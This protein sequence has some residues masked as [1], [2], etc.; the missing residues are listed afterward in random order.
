MRA[1]SYSQLSALVRYL[2]QRRRIHDSAQAVA[3]ERHVE[4][5]EQP[6]RTACQLH[7]R[8]DLRCVDRKETFTGLHLDNELFLDDEVE[9]VS[10]DKR[11][12]A[13]THWQRA[14]NLEL[15]TVF[16][17]LVGEARLVHGFHQAGAGTAVYAYGTAYDTLA[18]GI[19]IGPSS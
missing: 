6:D 3:Q 5:D 11:D 19:E 12:V 13:V 10:A 7:I 8:E 2:P 18:Q 17:E 16:R 1:W 14:L 9:S 15:E 4:I